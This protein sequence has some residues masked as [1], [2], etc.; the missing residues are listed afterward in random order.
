MPVTILQSATL[1]LLIEAAKQKVDPYDLALHWSAGTNWAT[2]SGV[3]GDLEMLSETG[4]LDSH[5]EALA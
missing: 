1:S 3:L 4:R 5:L 2:D